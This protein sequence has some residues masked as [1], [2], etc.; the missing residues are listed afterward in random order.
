MKYSSAFFFLLTM[1]LAACTNGNE[2]TEMIERGSPVTRVISTTIQNQ[3]VTL[4]LES[5][6]SNGC[7]RF[8]R[9][10]QQVSGNT[11]SVKV[12]G[13]E[14]KGAICTQNIISLQSVLT[15]PNLRSGSYRFQFWKSD[16]TTL[17]TTI[18]VP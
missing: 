18:Q 17:D 15:V 13:N 5:W 9:H 10:E 3:T 8:V 4:T 12:I 1:T 6:W 11:V 14:P 2:P 7:G 16:S